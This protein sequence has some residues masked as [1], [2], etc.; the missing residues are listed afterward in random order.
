MGRGLWQTH[1]V[2][3]RDTTRVD[4]PVRAST[5]GDRCERQKP[6]KRVSGCVGLAARSS[7]FKK[8]GAYPHPFT[9]FSAT[10]TA[11]ITNDSIAHFRTAQSSS[12]R[13]AHEWI[14]RQPQS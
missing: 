5:D 12:E 3:D 7:K 6:G 10:T 14:S 2:A 8:K 9:F 13:V 1:R 11:S 4:M